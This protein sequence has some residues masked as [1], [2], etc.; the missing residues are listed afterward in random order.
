V[1][2]ASSPITAAGHDHRFADGDWPF[3]DEIDTAAFTTVRVLEGRLPILEVYHDHDGDW[4]FLC[5]TTNATAD[6]RLICM[7][8]VYERFPDMGTFADLPPGWMAFREDER[9]AWQR[10]AHVPSE[11]EDE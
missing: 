7:G 2:D 3:D 5:G 11:D 6:C 9:A 1:S 8:C 10:S 4:Q